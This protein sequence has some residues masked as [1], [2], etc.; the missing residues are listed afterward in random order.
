M[1]NKILV[2]EDVEPA[3]VDIMF[4]DKDGF[5]IILFIFSKILFMYKQNRSKV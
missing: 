1:K 3:V 2:I 5:A 4:P